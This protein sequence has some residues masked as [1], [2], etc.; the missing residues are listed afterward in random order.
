MA[1]EERGTVVLGFLWALGERL[2]P[3]LVRIHG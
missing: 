3:E 2:V 1:G